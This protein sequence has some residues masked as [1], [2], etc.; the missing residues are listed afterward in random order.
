M[1]PNWYYQNVGISA[2]AYWE[3]VYILGILLLVIKGV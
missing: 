1:Y 2:S 3:I